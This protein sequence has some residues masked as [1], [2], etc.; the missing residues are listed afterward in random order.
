MNRSAK[1]TDQTPLE[2]EQ[3]ERRNLKAET[4]TPHEPSYTPDEFCTVERI[5]RVK[6]YEMWKRGI[7]PRYYMNGRC[8]RITHK[9]RLDWQAEREAEVSGGAHVTS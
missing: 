8:R 7:G 5:S 9:A 4:F 3:E 6:L 1:M 2:E